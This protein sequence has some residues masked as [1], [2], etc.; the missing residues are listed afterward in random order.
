MLKTFLL[1]THSCLHIFQSSSSWESSDAEIMEDPARSGPKYLRVVS[2]LT[3][4]GM[5]RGGRQT[6]G[7]L[8]AYLFF[9]LQN[10][11]VEL[12]IRGGGLDFCEF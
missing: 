1:L 8:Y 2:I 9:R 10:L 11:L 12:R 7:Q 5:K 4:V 3:Q 6:W